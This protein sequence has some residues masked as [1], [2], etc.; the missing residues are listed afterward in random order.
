MPRASVSRDPIGKLCALAAK[1]K[2]EAHHIDTFDRHFATPDCFIS[3]GIECFSLARQL[4]DERGLPIIVA[5]AFDLKWGSTPRGVN[6]RT[7]AGFRRQLWSSPPELILLHTTRRRKLSWMAGAVSIDPTLF[8]LSDVRVV[9]R[10]W[11]HQST[12]EYPRHLWLV[13][14]PRRQARG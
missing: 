4:R 9:L 11:Y 10:E 7:L 14:F 12:D 13:S 6:F 1:T 2:V 5:L 8:G 3:A